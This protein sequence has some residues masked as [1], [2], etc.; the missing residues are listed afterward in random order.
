MSKDK[1]SVN[2]LKAGRESIIYDV[3]FLIFG[4]E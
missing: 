3:D 1:I 4:N 2:Y